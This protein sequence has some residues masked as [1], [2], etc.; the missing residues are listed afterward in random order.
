MN[1][2]VWVELFLAGLGFGFGPCFL[3]CAPVISSYIFAKGLNHKEGLKWVIVFSIGRI[4]A[5]SILGLVAVAFVNTVG[6]QKNIF[7]QTAGILII[8]LLPL[9]EFGKENIK[10]CSFIH[11]YFNNKTQ[12]GSLLLGLFIGLTPCIPL[13]GILTYIACKSANIFYGFLNGLV[14]GLGTLFSPLILLGIFSGLLA[15]LALKLGKL[16]LVFKLIANIILVYFGIKLILW[17]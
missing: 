14:F 8:L 13:I 3:F 10:F 11:R 1:L 16:Y 5:Y 17:H 4:A 2:T 9:Y 6:I 15:N 7:K 12:T